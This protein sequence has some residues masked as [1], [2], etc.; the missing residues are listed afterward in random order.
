MII[1]GKYAWGCSENVRLPHAIPFMEHSGSILS[2][3]LKQSAKGK[4]I[5]HSKKRDSDFPTL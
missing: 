1:R 3:A 4:L 2:A 5:V